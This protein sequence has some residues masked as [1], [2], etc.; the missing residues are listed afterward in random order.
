MKFA[1]CFILQLKPQETF[2]NK[3]NLKLTTDH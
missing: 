2:D 3:C 1:K